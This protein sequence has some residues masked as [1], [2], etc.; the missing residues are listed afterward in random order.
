MEEKKPENSNE[1]SITLQLCNNNEE[2]TMYQRTFLNL[3]VF[4]FIASYILFFQTSCRT[5][6]D[7]PSPSP[8][9]VAEGERLLSQIGTVTIINQGLQKWL[10]DNPTHADR[11]KAEA[12]LQKVSEA[13]SLLDITTEDSR[14]LEKLQKEAGENP[15]SQQQFLES[16]IKAERENIDKLISELKEEAKPF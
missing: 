15:S 14:K 7:S 4:V 9:D 8:E 3:T 10:A 11:A 5:K 16:K 2:V 6:D 1:V 13:I 12:A